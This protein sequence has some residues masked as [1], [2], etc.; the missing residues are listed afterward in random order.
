MSDA[1][2]TEKESSV[3]VERS[4]PIN[5][6]T[7]R[8]YLTLLA[9]KLL[10]PLRERCG[11][12]LF[13]SDTLCVKYGSNTSLSEAATMQFIAKHT[14]IPV[15]RM[16]C[17]FAHQTRTYIVMERLPGQPVGAGWFN[18]SEENKA[19]LL[20]QLK[21]MVKGMRR[22]TPLADVGIA[23][24][25]GGLLY[26]PRLPGTSNCFG[27]FESISEFH[28]HLR[29]GLEAHP[30]H[31]PEISELISWQDIH[32]SPLVFTHGDLSSLNILASGDKITGIVDWETAG[33][34]PSYWE[35][36]TAWNVNLQNEFW[37][38]EVDKFLEHMPEELEMEK[39]RLRYFGDV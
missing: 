1:V 19:K 7:C 36:S 24:V 38:D 6:T 21:E 13:L 39:L 16:Y 12:V 10:K 2:V 15:P 23:S 17:A 11:T 33:W 27:P 26:D 34:Y 32:K 3:S 35:Y 22:I 14:S 31:K 4:R 20:E 28:K 37:R 8:R 25:D 5:D 18:R 30:E 29:G 9:I